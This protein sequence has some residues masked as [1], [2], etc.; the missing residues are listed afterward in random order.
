MTVGMLT[1]NRVSLKFDE[2]DEDEGGDGGGG[3]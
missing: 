2:D 3:A 1:R